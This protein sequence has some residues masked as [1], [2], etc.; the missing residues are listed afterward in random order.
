M[1]A[2]RES[3]QIGKVQILGNQKAF[4]VLR[5]LPDHGIDTAADSLILSCMNIMPERLQG[6]RDLLRK[7]FVELDSH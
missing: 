2:R 3:T 7:I 4:F 5:R 1:R 6:V